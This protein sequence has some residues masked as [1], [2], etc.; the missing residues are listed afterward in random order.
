MTT[1]RYMMTSLDTYNPPPAHEDALI[2][3]SPNVTAGVASHLADEDER[4]KQGLN[5][6]SAAVAVP[7]EGAVPAQV[8]AVCQQL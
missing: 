8:A 3:E 2:T 4:G 1:S 5:P 7:T 6:L